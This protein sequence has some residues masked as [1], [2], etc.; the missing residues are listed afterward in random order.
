MA[1]YYTVPSTAKTPYPALPIDLPNLAMYLQSAL[2]DSRRAMHD[3][4]SGLRKLA[5]CVE[6]CYLN[7]QEA[8]GGDEP[9]DRSRLGEV[10]RRLGRGNRQSRRGG[11]ED[12]FEYV[13]PFV[14][15]EWG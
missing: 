10:F 8:S 9:Q 6:S 11:N 7:E 14:A 4:S 2:E 15:D 1:I 5:K 12:V 13:T 3:T